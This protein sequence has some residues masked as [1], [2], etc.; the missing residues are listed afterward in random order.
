MGLKNTKKPSVDILLPYWGEFGLLKKAV[1]SVLAQTNKNWRLLIIDD[2]YPSDEAKKYYSN[3]PDKRVTYSRNKKNLG[4]VGNYNYALT[5]TLSNY[6]MMMGCDDIMLP[7]Y[8]ETALKNI[9]KADYYQPNVNV[10]NEKDVVYLPIVDRI[11]RV[12]R[13]RRQGIHKGESVAT[14]LCHGNWTYFPSL[15]WKTET[16][17]KY[18]FNA[19]QPNTQDL[20][21]QLDIIS[22]GGSVYIDNT[23][24][25]QYR[26]SAASFS[27]KAKSGTRFA[28]ENKTYDDLAKQF[29]KMGWNKAARAARA[30]LTTRLHQIIS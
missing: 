25:F 7:T 5:Q 21:T 15:L 10:I 19:E 9:G 27:S 24:T 13:P 2:C 29:H 18:G 16:L 22:N 17:K 3:F 30:H 4:L 28:E 20:T 6:C 11:K 26:R 23:I 8:I 12:V 14:S 1:D